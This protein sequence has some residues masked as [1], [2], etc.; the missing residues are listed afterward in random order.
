MFAVK[1]FNKFERVIYEMKFASLKKAEKRL[2][3][4]EKALS[5]LDSVDDIMLAVLLM[6]NGIELDKRLSE[7]VE[8]KLG[9][10]ELPVLEGL[11]DEIDKEKRTYDFELIMLTAYLLARSQDDEKAK[12]VDEKYE[13][14]KEELDRLFEAY[15]EDASMVLN[16]SLEKAKEIAELAKIHDIPTSGEEDTSMYE[17]E[18]E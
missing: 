6:K 8:E 18:E 17:V 12:K 15:E 5:R 14:F 1:L 9:F 10:E 4:K 2:G 3:A 16:E 11:T 7:L 13:A